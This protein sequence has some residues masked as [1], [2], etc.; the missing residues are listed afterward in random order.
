MDSHA[1]NLPSAV[2]ELENPDRIR[3]LETQVSQL[4]QAVTS[5]AVIDQAIGVIVALG[6]MTPEEAWDALRETS[7]CTN[8][9]LR[10]V[11][12][13]VVA[14][15]QGERELAADV[16]DELSRRLKGQDLQ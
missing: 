14:W 12:E 7:M 2:L 13:L 4:Q 11:A 3:H 1:D 6:R 16:R 9:K 10:H 15:G 8:I 5:D